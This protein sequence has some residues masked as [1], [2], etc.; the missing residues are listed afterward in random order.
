[1]IFDKF[2]NKRKQ[3]VGSG[4]FEYFLC[5]IHE[6]LREEWEKLRQNTSLI[7]DALADIEPM[8]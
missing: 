2:A 1:M 7:I 8:M 4:S 3:G 6:S 5:C